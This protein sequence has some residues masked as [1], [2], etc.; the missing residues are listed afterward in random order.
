MLDV[1][2]MRLQ[3]E[4]LNVS[5]QSLAESTGL[6][7]G[8]IEDEIVK[9]GWQRR[10]PDADE[11]PLLIEPGEDSFKLQSDAYIEKT[12][13][14]LHAYSLA[15]EV[16]LATRYLELEAGIISKANQCLM[17]IDPSMGPAAIKALSS[18]WK[19]M[20]KSATQAA[21]FSITQD[22]GGLPTV[23]VKDLSGRPI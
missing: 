12:R 7:D 3:Y 23:I 5:V 9:K 8:A 22:E 14:R 15:K 4:I 21:A 18:L 17:H 19:D 16:L 6:P 1:P 10:W 13:K 20:Q 11:P 2:L